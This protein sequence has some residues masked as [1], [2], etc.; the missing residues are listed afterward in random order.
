ME[1]EIVKEET[2]NVI[3]PILAVR[4]IL[5]IMLEETTPRDKEAWTLGPRSYM[6]DI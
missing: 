6:S 3:C 5:R 4:E 2:E 1:Y